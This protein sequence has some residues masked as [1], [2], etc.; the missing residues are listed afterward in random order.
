M[1]RDFSA[2]FEA[3]RSVALVGKSG[4]GKSTVVQLV[5]RF[6]DVTAGSIVSERGARRRQLL[7]CR[8]STAST[9][10]RRVFDTCDRTWRS[11]VKSRRS[12]I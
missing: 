8:R 7:V 1:L 4:S 2:T 11:S 5:E 10:A 12:S 6:Y 3:A 9:C